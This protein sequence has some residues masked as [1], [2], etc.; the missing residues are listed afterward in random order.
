MICQRS[1]Q[2]CNARG[3]SQNTYQPSTVVRNIFRL[4][5]R[6]T[7]GVARDVSNNAE[8]T[9]IL[10][11]SSEDLR[12]DDH[13]GLRASC[14]SEA[15]LP[16][17]ILDAKHL[18]DLQYLENGPQLL[19]ASLQH[20]QSQLQAKGSDLI[21]RHGQPSQTLEALAVEIGASEIMASHSIKLNASVNSVVIS[22]YEDAYIWDNSNFSINYRQWTSQR[23]PASSI[24]DAPHSLPPIPSNISI[25]P[26]PTLEDIQKMCSFDS[27]KRSDKGE[28]DD[29][30]S[31]INLNQLC[32]QLVSAIVSSCKDPLQ[33]LDMY[34]TPC[35]EPSEDLVKLLTSSSSTRTSSTADPFMQFSTTSGRISLNGNIYSSHQVINAAALLLELP[36]SPGSSFQQLLGPWLQLG[37]L[38]RR[39]VFDRASKSV[40]AI[41]PQRAAA[42]VRAVELSEFHHL[43]STVG[44]TQGRPEEVF[45]ALGGLQVK[46][47]KWRGLSNE[48]CVVEPTDALEGTPALLLVHGFGAFGDQ[49]RG[50]MAALAKAGYRVFAPTLPGFGRSEKAAVPYSQDLWRDFL[51]DFTVQVVGGP[52]VVAGNSIGGFIAASMAADYPQLA[53]GLILLNSAGPVDPSFDIAAWRRACES[54]TPPPKFVVQLISR[55]LFWY[56]E[57][58]IA[59]TLKWLYPTNPDRADEWLGTEIFRAACDLG[60]LE[61]FQ[62]VFYLPPPRALNYLVSDLFQGPTLVLQGA[63][64]PLND[65]KGRAESLQRTC[66]DNVE[67]VLLQAGH[68][69]H[70]EQPEQVNQGILKFMRDRIDYKKRLAVL[71]NFAVN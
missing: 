17:Y 51:R 7:Q 67:V 44:A 62:S 53:A 48:Y 40:E 26:F 42:A 46:Q 50:N 64:D 49:W 9:T 30:S 61:V 59:R 33:I 58:T 14:S 1:I 56:L 4:R 54:K 65:A 66:P 32:L 39:R 22:R 41:L 19:F 28:N 24:P 10:L 20:L 34:L 68:C 12:A 11:Y 52:V 47:Y 21:V 18:Q 60:S 25:C 2:Q 27:H 45:S 5:P 8:R 38:S 31:N 13:P 71:G 15:L 37:A 23:G 29:L 69:P 36:S 35:P 57:L 6:H 55:A 70:D 16:V 63:L 3:S 43:L